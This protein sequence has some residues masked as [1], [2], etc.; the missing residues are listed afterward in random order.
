VSAVWDFTGALVSYKTL[1]SVPTVDLTFSAF[2]SH[3]NQLYNTGTASTTSFARG[4]VAYL[5]LSAGFHPAPR[6]T[7]K[8]PGSGPQG[9]TVTITGTGFTGATLVHFGT[10][11]AVQSTVLS[12]TSISAV[13]PA[14]RTGTVNV[15]VTGPGGTSSTSTSDRFTFVVIPRVTGLTP[16][17]GTAD[18]GTSVTITG[19]NFT[20][21]TAVAFGGVPASFKVVSDKS[22]VAVAPA[23]PDSGVTVAVTVTAPA[24]TSALSTADLFTYT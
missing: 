16:S 21:A 9:S 13:T 10:L 14:I 3:G 20:G 23:G 12:D 6:V 5:L 4:D 1:T 22:I 2:D 15:K 17:Q 11:P 18:G 7:S 24:G 19:V 8:T